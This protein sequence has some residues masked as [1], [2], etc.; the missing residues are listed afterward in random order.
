[1]AAKCLN[2]QGHQPS[3]ESRAPHRGEKDRDLCNEEKQIR[4]LVG[5]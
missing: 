2:Q 1:M 4:D 3:R 5:I